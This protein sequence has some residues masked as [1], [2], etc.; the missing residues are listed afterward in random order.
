MRS[1]LKRRESQGALLDVKELVGEVTTLRGRQL[2]CC[3]QSAPIRATV[4]GL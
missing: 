1:M 4:F 3:Q 2:S